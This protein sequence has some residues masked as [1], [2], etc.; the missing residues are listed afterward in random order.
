MTPADRALAALRRELEAAALA[1]SGLEAALEAGRLLGLLDWSNVDEVM[2]AEALEAA[3]FER[4]GAEL[5]R[6]AGAAA[7]PEAE[8]LHVI[9]EAYAYG[10]HT[11]LPENLVSGLAATGA[12]QAVAVTVAAPEGFA[13]RVAA[14]GA[15]VHRLG[16]GWADR[17]AGL[18]A[19]GRRTRFVALH[20]HPDDLGAALAAR[21]LRAEGRRVL[22]VNHSDHAFAFGPG[23]ADAVLEI[24]GFGWRLTEARR[25]ARAQ[26]FLG[27]P[28]R[29]P[30]DPPPPAPGGP[31]V[32][33]G[34]WEKY[35]PRAGEPGFPGFL[36]A[37]LPRTDR[38]VEL[39]GPRAED[40][41]W[42]EVLARHPGRVRLHGPL[43]FA[44]ASARVAAAGAYVER[45]PRNGSTALMEALLANRTVFA[46]G[47]EAGGD[48]GGYGLVDA[49]R[50]PSAE[51]LTE[52]LLA[53]L[54][55]GREPPLEAEMRRR[56]REEFGVAAVTARLIAA[57]EGRPS[58]IPEELPRAPRPLNRQVDLWRGHGEVNLVLR[59][60]P[61]LPLGRRLAVARRRAGGGPLRRRHF[62]RG[63]LL[64]WA[65]T[66]RLS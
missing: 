24:S 20:I 57:A 11:R 52:A 50:F 45:F 28:V 60:A 40:P 37:L 6:R 31:I 23:A 39:I 38:E 51:V 48:A 63:T 35:R 8:W 55:T 7:G 22:F 21:A 15:A 10:G 41:W 30:A 54:A 49:L 16:G 59:P 19:L 17:A 62:G 44:E 18:L 25:A 12:R 26:G 53:F 32:S 9:S 66:G 36:L 14:A 4:H 13:E 47:G 27:I 5:R 42:A 56:I 3:L 34:D 65:S 58:P 33:M 61:A 1:A 2:A 43:P 29:T 46:L 64:R